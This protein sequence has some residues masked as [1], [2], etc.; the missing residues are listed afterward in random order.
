MICS[1]SVTL[2]T[3]TFFLEI[4]I[5]DPWSSFS[6]ALFNELKGFL[7]LRTTNAPGAQ[8]MHKSVWH[9]QFAQTALTKRMYAS[10]EP[11][12]HL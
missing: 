4:A 12:A 1:K 5:P 2:R 6:V 7:K 9:M 8:E 11:L 10:P 3:R